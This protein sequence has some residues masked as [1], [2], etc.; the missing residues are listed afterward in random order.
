M[1]DDNGDADNGVTG[2]NGGNNGDGTMGDDGVDDGDGVTWD[3]GGGLKCGGLNL[4]G[5]GGDQLTSS[6]Q[7]PISTFFQVSTQDPTLPC[8]PTSDNQTDN[9]HYLLS[10]DAS[11][12]GFIDPISGCDHYHHRDH[13]S[14][15]PYVDSYHACVD[16][17]DHLHTVLKQA[18]PYESSSATAWC[19]SFPSHMT[20]HLFIPR[21][22]LLHTCNLHHLRNL[23]IVKKGEKRE[24]TTNNK[25]FSGNVS[26]LINPWCYPP[27]TSK[28]NV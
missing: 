20:P 18:P 27:K 7:L 8:G 25:G 1:G 9:P 17:M 15:V 26:Q 19:M 11:D 5:G 2:D 24:N 6:T 23:F 4:K 14:D 10:G 3:K 28:N 13:L 12:D 21:L 16:P 22:H